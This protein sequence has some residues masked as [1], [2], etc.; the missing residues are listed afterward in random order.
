MGQ[1]FWGVLDL[2]HYSE[3]PE[4]TYFMRR[5][6]L[7]RYGFG[8]SSSRQ[9]G[10]I[11]GIFGEGVRWRWLSMSRRMALGAR[12]QREWLGPALA[13][14]TTFHHG[15]SNP[16]A[17]P[18]DLRTSH[19]AHLPHTIIGLRFHLLST[20]NLWIWGLNHPPPHPEFWSQITS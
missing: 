11:D 5:K 13:F 1:H 2:H 9:S 3:M 12:K 19:K 15:S 8:G 4:V 20:F 18:G 16:T 17:H 7:C 10:P 6:G 14:L